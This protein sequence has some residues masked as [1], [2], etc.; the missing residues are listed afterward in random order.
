M[1]G[2]LLSVSSK[3]VDIL[4]SSQVLTFLLSLS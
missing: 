2:Y 3:Y 1:G 4:A